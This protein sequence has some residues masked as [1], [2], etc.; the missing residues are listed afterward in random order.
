[1]PATELGHIISPLFRFSGLFLGPFYT[2]KVKMWISTVFYTVTCLQIGVYKKLFSLSIVV[3]VEPTSSKLIVMLKGKS[4][5][6]KQPSN[7]HITALRFLK[8]LKNIVA[9]LFTLLLYWL[10][11]IP[12]SG[13]SRFSGPFDVDGPS[14]LNRDTTVLGISLTFAKITGNI[15]FA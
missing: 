10:G 9:C 2:K 7:I 1:M 14:S 13:L 8:P 3:F 12:F 5:W 11:M 6:H 15:M 4:K